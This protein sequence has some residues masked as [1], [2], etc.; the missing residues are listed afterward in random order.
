L[1]RLLSLRAPLAN[2]LG[3]ASILDKENFSNPKNA[4]V[5]ESIDISAK[6]L[7]SKIKEVVQQT[8]YETL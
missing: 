8:V 1:K 3:L 4:S 5:I 2:I 6:E 7:D